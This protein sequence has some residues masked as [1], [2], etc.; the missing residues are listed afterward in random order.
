M[1]NKIKWDVEINYTDIVTNSKRYRVERGLINLVGYVW[2][3]I[4][5]SLST[6]DGDYYAETSDKI[7]HDEFEL[8]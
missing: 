3:F 4:P 8:R 1:L 6:K 5:G 7:N 2:K